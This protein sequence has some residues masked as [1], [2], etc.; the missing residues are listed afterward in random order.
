MLEQCDLGAY[1]WWRTGKV[2]LL[3]SL[4][5]C[6][7]DVYCC[8]SLLLSFMPARQF[9]FSCF[10]SSAISI[11]FTSF[12]SLTV[13]FDLFF[14]AMAKLSKEKLEKCDQC[15][16]VYATKPGLSRHKREKHGGK[17]GEK[18]IVYKCSHCGKEDKRKE[19]LKRHEV[20]C[21]GPKKAAT[22]GAPKQHV[23]N[24]HK[25]LSCQ[26]TF[27]SRFSLNRHFPTCKKK[28]TKKKKSKHLAPTML[29]SPPSET[30]K[31]LPF[32]AMLW[33]CAEVGL[34]VVKTNIENVSLANSS[35][36]ASAEESDI[37][38]HIERASCSVT[39]IVPMSDDVTV[40]NDELDE[41]D[42]STVVLDEREPIS[43]DVEMVT[44][45]EFTKSSGELDEP[46]DVVIKPTYVLD[47]RELGSEV[48]ETMVTND[49]LFNQSSHMLDEQEPCSAEME[50][51]NGDQFTGVR[52][53]T[54][55]SGV[56][57]TPA[58]QR[59][60]HRAYT[61]TAELIRNWLHKLE[62]DYHGE[63]LTK[64]LSLAGASHLIV[65]PEKKA[66]GIRRT[67][68]YVINLCWK[69][70]K[71]HAT[72]SNMSTSRP[73]TMPVAMM[74][75]NPLLSRV[76][77]E[78][79]SFVKHTTKRGV[80]RYEHTFMV[81]N[82]TDLT[83]YQKFQSEHSIVIGRSTFRKLK[84]FY[85]RH[86]K[87]GD[88]ET[89]CCIYHVNFRNSFEALSKLFK[90][91][92][93]VVGDDDDDECEDN[94]GR[95]AVP[96]GISE[97]SITID[98]YDSFKKRLLQNCQKDQHG[99]LVTQ[100]ESGECGHWKTIFDNLNQQIVL[101][102]N[103]L[104]DNDIT[105]KLS[106]TRFGYVKTEE[107]GN[108]LEPDTTPLS[109]AEICAY[110]K[111]KLP[112]F[113]KHSNVYS[114]D[115]ILWKVM[116]PYTSVN[117][118]ALTVID[119]AENLSI[120]VPREPQS[121]YWVR[122][123]VSIMSGITETTESKKT[124]HGHLSENRIHDQV[125]TAESIRKI[126]HHLPQ[127]SHYVIRSDNAVHF[128]SAQCFFD[129]QEIANEFVSVIV[130]C[131]GITG[132]GK[133]EIDSCG[134]HIK[135]AIRKKIQ[136]GSKVHNTDD[137]LAVLD[138]KFSDST[139]PSYCF[140]KVES[141]DLVNQRNKLLKY[142]FKT[143]VGSSDFHVLVFTPFSKF[144]LASTVLCV[145][146]ECLDRNYSSCPN[147]KEYFPVV[148][149]YNKPVTRGEKVEVE[150]VE[151]STSSVIGS[152]VTKDS[153]F[154]VKAESSTHDFFLLLCTTEQQEHLDKEPLTDTS[155]HAINLG[156]I[157]ITGSYLEIS[158]HGK[159]SITFSLKKSSK[160]VY[161]L[162]G[163]VFFPQVP[164]KKIGE[165]SYRLNNDMVV[166]L[167]IRSSM[168][169]SQ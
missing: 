148:T 75:S 146:D 90:S 118:S 125:F 99:L 103:K 69:F 107:Y 126:I 31:H 44:D 56:R 47:E 61:D 24:V 77:I 35:A 60:L 13:K 70:W 134:G 114:R 5:F 98:N 63:Y 34:D 86:S 45:D 78:N 160:D 87:E 22:K 127:L 88:I 151:S 26:E 158:E 50:R 124:Y 167:N 139:S 137:C 89:C 101:L 162:S 18:E 153:I 113:I 11:S 73:A 46:E 71:K 12:Q 106:F 130:R 51:T 131:Y 133:G 117:G 93:K 110:L 81:Q 84:P 68:D 94:S 80:T 83:I 109:L 40:S 164:I 15:D 74:K 100:C 91:C 53:K 32:T 65:K 36:S 156:D 14:S 33:L 111:S 138:E 2:R 66:R 120:P 140:E 143:V 129:L 6:P 165:N 23:H 39:E 57:K 29:Q 163:A 7:F 48:V 128:K 112:A 54:R 4:L 108:R 132:H 20:A 42:E 8:Q 16:A 19:N 121:M 55:S 105:K 154:A 136:T 17:K 3:L 104:K 116:K 27:A 58:N 135:N 37:M 97:I 168:N 92:F 21:Q 43:V 76:D 64:S 123:Q 85:I 145:C 161:V 159:K 52:T 96:E 119:Y 157:Y 82:E 102:D 169:T 41:S 79:E 122:K 25:C 142:D 95:V 115:F 144:F 30:G 49:D 141:E 38:F 59:Q 10:L 150:E 147:F 9:V 67:S 28:A 152:M 1:K 155:G 72:V 62:P 166:E 149:I